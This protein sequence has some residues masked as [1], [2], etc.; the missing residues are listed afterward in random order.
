M[1]DDAFFQPEL[2][3]SMMGSLGRTWTVGGLVCR[4]LD[5]RDTPLQKQGRRG[6]GEGFAR[7]RFDA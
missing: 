1:S 3:W 6:V 2:G 7:G 5:R 4:L